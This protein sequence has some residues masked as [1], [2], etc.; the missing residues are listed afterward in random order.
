MVSTL[1]QLLNNFQTSTHLLK[2]IQTYH[3]FTK[4]KSQCMI[5]SERN[6]KAHPMVK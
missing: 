2:T 6:G 3:K 4:N 5:F 1:E